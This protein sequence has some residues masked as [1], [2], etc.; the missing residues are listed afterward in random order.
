M[1]SGV[2]WSHAEPIPKKVRRIL[3]PE[4]AIPVL[5]DKGWVFTS[6]GSLAGKGFVLAPE[7]YALM[8]GDVDDEVN[9]YAWPPC[10]IE[11]VEDDE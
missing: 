5:I 4:R 1:P 10:I 11:E 3:P 2:F 8:G 6:T 9:K 7:M